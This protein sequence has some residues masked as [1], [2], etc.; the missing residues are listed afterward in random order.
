MEIEPMSPVHA[1]AVSPPDELV[2]DRIVI[3]RYRM[4]DA[5]ALFEAVDQSRERLR[6][7]M[8][9]LDSHQTL[10]DAEDYCHRVAASWAVRSGFA[11][12]IWHRE[13]GRFLGG[14][15]LH[16]IDWSVPSFDIGYWIRDGEVGK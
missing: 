6:Q 1:S 2:G 5:P 12:G 3:R 15:G 16:N 4:A 9:W 7:W 14:T 10:A 13:T 8:S 11:L